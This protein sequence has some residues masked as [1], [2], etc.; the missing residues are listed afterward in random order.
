MAKLVH[1][2]KVKVHR[3][4]KK[5]KIKRVQF[6]GFRDIV[7]MG[8]HGGVAEYFKIQPDEPLPHER[9]AFRFSLGDTDIF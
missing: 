3:E 7:R 1:L 8:L 4:A 2:S 6:E 5:K 9:A